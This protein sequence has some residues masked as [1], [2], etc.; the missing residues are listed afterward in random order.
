MLTTVS[1]PTV[2]PKPRVPLTTVAALVVPDRLPPLPTKTAAPVKVSDKALALVNVTPLL[3]AAVLTSPISSSNPP[4][5]TSAPENA[6]SANVPLKRVTSAGPL[7]SIAT[8][9][10]SGP[11]DTSTPVNALPERF[12]ST[13]TLLANRVSSSIPV[14]LALSTNP[15]KANLAFAWTVML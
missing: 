15:L 12:T 14:R 6:L 11:V 5:A 10:P 3:G 13:P 2:A 9:V 4:L 1:L 8:G 7:K